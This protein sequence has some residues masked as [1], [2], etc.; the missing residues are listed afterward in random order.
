MKTP[1]QFQTI[2]AV[3]DISGMEVAISGAE[4]AGKSVSNYDLFVGFVEELEE[5][6]FMVLIFQKAM[7]AEI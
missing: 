6:L 4:V 7:L 1:T 5:S 3:V 2:T